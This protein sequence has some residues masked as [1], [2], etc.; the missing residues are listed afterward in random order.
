MLKRDIVIKFY[1]IHAIFSN[2]GNWN[3]GSIFGPFGG[4]GIK[5]VMF[6]IKIKLYVIFRNFF[7]GRGIEINGEATLFT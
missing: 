7:K 3:M 6:I 1:N 5:A 4:G 2:M